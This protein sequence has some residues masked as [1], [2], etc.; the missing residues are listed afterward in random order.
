MIL[1]A[2]PVLKY[3]A[4]GIYRKKYSSIYRAAKCTCITRSSICRAIKNNQKAG[5]YYWR[6]YTN[7]YELKIVIVKKKGM[8]VKIFKRR[9]YILEALSLLEAAK[10]TGVPLST[11]RTHLN[12]S[13]LKNS[14]YTFE[15]VV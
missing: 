1:I 5:G 2:R 7:D 10:V 6:Y 3:D 9:N 15:K 14:D 13:K 12:K 8:A 4:E 11:I